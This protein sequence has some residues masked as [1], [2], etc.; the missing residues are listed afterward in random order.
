[1]ESC[2]NLLGGNIYIYIYAK[3][4]PNWIYIAV[5]KCEKL[6]LLVIVF[7]EIAAIPDLLIL[8]KNAYVI[9]GYFPTHS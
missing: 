2:A 4:L 9:L 8:A 3:I 5:Y 1:M 6:A 7:C